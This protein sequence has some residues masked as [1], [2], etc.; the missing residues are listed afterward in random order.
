METRG[1]RADPDEINQEMSSH[2]LSCA[3][4]GAK[5]RAEDLARVTLVVNFGTTTHPFSVL[6]EKHCINVLLRC[7]HESY[8]AQ[9]CEESH[10]FEE[11]D[12]Y[13]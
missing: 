5:R 7:L 8:C 4:C 10:E 6:M 9:D 1:D 11:G 2:E 3:T 12:E 13:D